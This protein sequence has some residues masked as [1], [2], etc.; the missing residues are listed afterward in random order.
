MEDQVAR[1]LEE[2]LA[3][4]ED[5]KAVESTTSEG[6]TRVDLHF[7]YGKDIYIALSDASTRLD[8]AKRFLPD[9]IAP[10]VI[11]KMDPSQIPVMEFV[12][13][14]N[15]KSSVELKSWADHNFRITLENAF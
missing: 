15:L 3:I 5:V 7:Q 11:Y 9:T 8:R 13:S 6:S 10:P 4:T 2:Q 14:S 1:Q 12:A